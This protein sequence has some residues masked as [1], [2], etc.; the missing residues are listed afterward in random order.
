MTERKPHDDDQ[1]QLPEDLRRL[2]GRTQVDTPPELDQSIR[3]GVLGIL[4]GQAKPKTSPIIKPRYRPQRWLAMAAV[5]VITVTTGVLTSNRFGTKPAADGPPSAMSGD[6]GLDD[7]LNVRGGNPAFQSAIQARQKLLIEHPEFRDSL[8]ADEQ[9]SWERYALSLCS[10]SKIS[11]ADMDGGTPADANVANGS[12]L[13][14][15]VHARIDYLER[16]YQ[17]PAGDSPE[18]EYL[19][20]YDTQ[21]SIRDAGKGLLNV[22]LDGIR[23]DTQHV[24]ELSGLAKPKDGRYVMDASSPH[25]PCVIGVQLSGRDANVS[26]T[27][28]TRQLGQGLVVVGHYRRVGKLIP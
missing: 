26:M 2:H 17:W 6:A 18:G 24:G 23:A 8:N 15:R 25:E 20:G 9:A 27:G 11:P 12:C 5:L 28:C 1:M 4:A 3:A 13:K 19:S 10:D 21:L 22:K 14:D 7:L 16:G